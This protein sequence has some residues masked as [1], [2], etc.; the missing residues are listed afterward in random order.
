MYLINVLTCKL[1][2][3]ETDPPPYAILSHRWR[4]EEV[5]Y[6]TFHKPDQRIMFKGFAKIRAVCDLT[7][8]YG[9]QYA[10]IDTCCIDKSSSAELS[11]AINSMYTWYQGSHICFVYLDDCTATSGWDYLDRIIRMTTRPSEWFE[12]GWTLQELIAPQRLSFFNNK[13]EYLGNKE[14]LASRLSRVTDID[15]SLLQHKNNLSSYSVAERMRWAAKRKTTRS[16]DMAYCLLGLFD[17][18]MPLLYGEGTKAFLRLQEEIV[19][20]IDDHT[21]FAWR[22]STFSPLCVGMF[23]D[24]PEAFAHSTN[25]IPLKDLTIGTEISV[26]ASGLKTKTTALPTIEQSKELDR[27]R[28]FLLLPLNCRWYGTDDGYFVAILLVWV[29]GNKYLRA[30][31]ESVFAVE[32]SYISRDTTIC[33]CKGLGQD[34]MIRLPQDSPALFDKI[35]KASLHETPSNIRLRE[36]FPCNIFIQLPDDESITFTPTL[37][38]AG[39]YD[40]VRSIFRIID[41]PSDA[42]PSLRSCKLL[43]QVERRRYLL[44]MIDISTVIISDTDRAVN[45]YLVM[46]KFI[47]GLPNRASM[48]S[49]NRF[50]VQRR[51]MT[52][53]SDNET[54]QPITNSLLLAEHGAGRLLRV[55]FQSVI[56]PSPV[57]EPN[58]PY[59]YLAL[60]VIRSNWDPPPVLT[61]LS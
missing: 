52:R 51:I 10:W 53:E 11:E 22:R 4:E 60:S 27:N 6:K 21:I 45:D 29:R 25:T 41:A 12:R 33:V 19:R 61:D 1:E 14:E 55:S 3:F 43:F 44:V 20:N 46:S 59:F 42:E 8:R 34:T 13:W 58:T 2:R 5:Q 47:D 35:T 16:E 31:P 28:K 26:T 54:L 39:H 32:T 36:P 15:T 17:V 56:P 18:N 48:Y 57:S 9:L 49:R 7:E 37:T 40:Q 38:T 24:S 50:K 23:A 30:R